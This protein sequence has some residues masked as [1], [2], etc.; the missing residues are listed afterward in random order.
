MN[1]L[2]SI[3]MPK[4]SVIT[5]NYNNLKGLEKTMSSVLKQSSKDYEYIIIDGGSKD[6]S[7][8]LVE[9]ASKKIKYSVSEKD[10]GIYHA[11][12]KGIRQATGEYLVFLNSG[13][14]FNDDEVLNDFCKEN[15][16]AD[17]IY[18]N[19]KF[20]DNRIWILPSEITFEFLFH[21]ALAHPA[22]FTK[23]AIFEKCGYYDEE[24]K[25]ASD[26]LHYTRAIIQYNAIPAHLDRVISIFD[27][28]GLSSTNT[29]VADQERKKCLEKYFPHLVKD[30]LKMHELKKDNYRFSQSRLATWALKIQQTRFYKLLR[31]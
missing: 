31:S 16:G 2:R 19:L 23:K 14:V 18:G 25:I 6:G 5:I 4:V 15:L 7:W 10:N 17:I 28:T 12:N 8:E 21:N 3:S 9:N 20:T 26:W 1:L 29:G 27:E 11:M 13:D 22:L 24:L 30:Y